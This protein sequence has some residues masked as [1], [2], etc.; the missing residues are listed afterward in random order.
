MTVAAACCSCPQVASPPP[1][2]PAG[3]GGYGGAGHFHHVH[4]FHHSRPEY[5]LA[6]RAGALVTQAVRAALRQFRTTAGIAA[7]EHEREE[8]LARRAAAAAGDAAA[9]VPPP[10]PD[11]AEGAPA[12]EGAAAE[13]AA[14]AASSDAAVVGEGDGTAEAPG[15][16]SEADGGAAG[17]VAGGAS[18]RAS[19][20]GGALFGAGTGP[21]AAAATASTPFGNGPAAAEP[22]NMWAAQEAAQ[23]RHP[24]RRVRLHLCPV[25]APCLLPARLRR[26][27]PCAARFVDAHRAASPARRS[28]CCCATRRATARPWRARPCCPTARRR[29]GPGARARLGLTRTPARAPQRAHSVPTHTSHAWVGSS[30]HAWRG[31][32]RAAVHSRALT[33]RVACGSLLCRHFVCEWAP[34]AGGHWDAALL[35]SSPQ[36]HESAVAFGARSRQGKAP[37]S[38]QACVEAFLQ[39]R[40]RR[41]RSPSRA[42]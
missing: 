20:E 3:G 34:D 9:E 32:L 14:A 33:R 6:G 25:F 35:E 15:G 16:K 18:G 21:A 37:V 5:E 36:D 2:P 22:F 10:A 24:V 19:V 17:V 13:D 31:P 4:T 28:G 41:N 23:Q 38:L 29:T 12:P 39:V 8:R 7:E 11:A 27:L 1:A 26:D 40:A 42:C 30:Q